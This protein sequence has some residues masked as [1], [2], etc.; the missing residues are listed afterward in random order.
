MGLYVCEEREICVKARM[1]GV[2]EMGLYVWGGIEREEGGGR[3]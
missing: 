3:G 2:G 1:G